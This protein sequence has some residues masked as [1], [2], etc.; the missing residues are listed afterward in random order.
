MNVGQN[1]TSC[2]LAYLQTGSK[3]REY[4]FT[5]EVK[6]PRNNAV[7]EK[8]Y[9]TDETIRTATYGR[10]YFTSAIQPRFLITDMTI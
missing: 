8:T 10:I 9:N 1:E 7:K 5:S 2:T 3:Q 6:L 4:K